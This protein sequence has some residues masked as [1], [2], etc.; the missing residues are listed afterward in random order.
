MFET[1]QRQTQA[2]NDAEDAARE[3]RE[4]W[5]KRPH[6]VGPK[7]RDGRYI[8]GGRDLVDPSSLAMRFDS[9]VQNRH[10]PAGMARHVIPEQ[11]QVVHHYETP[12]QRQAH[13][14]G[15]VSSQHQ[16]RQQPGLETIVQQQE[17]AVPPRVSRTTHS[18]DP[19]SQEIFARLDGKPKK[20]CDVSL[21]GLNVS[22]RG[23]ALF[24]AEDMEN[25]YSVSETYDADVDEDNPFV[26]F[27]RVLVSR[28]EQAQGKYKKHMV[29]TSS[30]A[31]KDIKTTF[32]NDLPQRDACYLWV[33]LIMVDEDVLRTERP[34][35]KV[36]KAMLT[37]FAKK[38]GGVVGS[39]FKKA[40]NNGKY[41]LVAYCNGLFEA[42]A[43]KN[44]H[45][46]G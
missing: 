40:W 45:F 17:V 30:K 27:S 18:P 7:S 10:P 34:F 41:A 25:L 38:F 39:D 20:L 9:Q 23:T 2:A 33:V 13:T 31:A 6:T 42:F 29:E 37:D 24:P 11:P 44:G 19:A 21:A 16:Q 43:D 5:H 3:H 36:T 32:V 14:A 28:I 46:K 22:P 26:E 1:S 12:Q 8:N 4:H 15:N 35:S